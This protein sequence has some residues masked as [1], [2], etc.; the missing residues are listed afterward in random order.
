VASELIGQ[1]TDQGIYDEVRIS[2][3]CHFFYHHLCPWPDI[4]DLLCLL[5]IILI[6]REAI[7]I[8]RQTTRVQH[9]LQKYVL[10]SDSSHGEANC[11]LVS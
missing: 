1:L 3:M 9:L 5:S 7:F 2:L 10:L 11:G 8:S 6:Q 4:E